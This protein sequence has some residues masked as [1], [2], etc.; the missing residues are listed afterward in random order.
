MDETVTPVE[1]PVAAPVET[2]VA[3]TVSSTPPEAPTP[4]PAPAVAPET[5]TPI[6]QPAVEPTAPEAKEPASLL[7]E[8]AEPAPEAKPDADKPATEADAKA[9]AVEEAPTEA[10]LPTYDVFTVPEGVELEDAQVDSFVGLLGNFEKSINP[11]GSP[12][13]HAA[14][15]Q[16]GQQLLDQYTT[17]V[18][19]LAERV[20]EVNAETW[21]RTNE[22]WKSEFFDDPEIGGNRKETTLKNCASV[23]NRFGGNANQVAELRQVLTATGAGNN[24]AVIRLLNNIAGF[25]SEGHAVAGGNPE[26][27]SQ[28]RQERRY[29]KGNR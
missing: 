18:E 27:Q 11:A 26:P 17:E 24:L 25:T 6:E 20:H 7:S 19:G 14:V 10:P 15:Q 21:R 12:E 5:S 13:V 28:T 2:P 4:E 1:A 16:L 8:A 22:N 3:E 23:L 9:P 29:G